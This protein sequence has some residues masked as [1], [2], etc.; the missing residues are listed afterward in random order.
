VDSSAGPNGDNP[1][2]QDAASFYVPKGD[3]FMPPE[4]SGPAIADASGEDRAI[5]YDDLGDL[6]RRMQRMGL[7]EY[8]AGNTR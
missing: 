6:I 4:S 1:T 8:A 5:G 2:V 3:R 7:T